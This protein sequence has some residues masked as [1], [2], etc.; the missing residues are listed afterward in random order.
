VVAASIANERLAW[1]PDA[2]LGAAYETTALGPA[3]LVRPA[4]L[5]RH[6]PG[7]ATDGVTNKAR[8]I[9]LH[10]HGFNDYFFQTHLA[11]AFLAAGYLFYAVDLRRCGRSWRT[12]QVPHDMRDVAE[13]AS[14]IDRAVRTLRALHP[15]LPVILHAH[16]TGGLTAALWCHTTRHT[17]GPDAVIFDAPFL[18]MPGSWAM[19]HL[20]GP[21][22][23]LLGALAPERVMSRDRS[24]Y[25]TTLRERWT[26][27]ETL[28]CTGGM[29]KSV[30][31]VRA[32]TR[33]Q[34]RAARGLDITCPVLVALSTA[35]SRDA[36]DNPLATTTDSVLDVAAIAA[37]A[38]RL[39]R[40]VTV[41]RI[42][43]GIH[44]L[45]LSLP[46]P[47]RVYLDRVVAWLGDLH[48]DTVRG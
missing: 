29:A 16:S 14:D 11:D 28:K 17:E 7:G 23:E 4:D 18:A 13:P 22:A 5:A 38:P 40:Q 8:G 42:E 20:L 41:T 15:G 31:W 36:P 12:G 39:G 19:R 6:V 34:R 44:E 33:A 2:L 43:G 26:F 21:V 30:G 1:C 3:T 9:V 25:A 45:S 24:W 27:D 47:R 35:S 37:I 10:I 32:V 48:L 46:G